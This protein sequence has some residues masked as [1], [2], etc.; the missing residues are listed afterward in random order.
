MCFGET[1]VLDGHGRTADARADEPHAAIN[2]G[3]I[4][5]PCFECERR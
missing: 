4:D 5:E 2:A 3:F 1:E